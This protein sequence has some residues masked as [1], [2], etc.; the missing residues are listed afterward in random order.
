MLRTQIGRCN[1]I[2]RVAKFKEKMLMC[3]L[4][5]VLDHT[6]CCQ[7]DQHSNVARE[8]ENSS[9]TKAWAGAYLEAI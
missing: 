9:T 4:D 2:F 7:R 5:I 8:V 6:K 1:A 3:K